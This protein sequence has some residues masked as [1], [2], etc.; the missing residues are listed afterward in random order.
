MTKSSSSGSSSDQQRSTQKTVVYCNGSFP[1]ANTTAY[2]TAKMKML[3]SVTRAVL[4]PSST[5]LAAIL[6]VLN[7][8]AILWFRK[9]KTTS[10]AMIELV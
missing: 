3:T 6:E 7:L 5:N 2:N 1:D 9:L 8:D 10:A 4:L